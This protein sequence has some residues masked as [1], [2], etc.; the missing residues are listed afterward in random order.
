MKTKLIILSILVLCLSVAPAMADFIVPTEGAGATPFGVSSDGGSPPITVQEILDYITVDPL[1]KGK[2]LAQIAPLLDYTRAGYP[3]SVIALDDTILDSW[4]SYWNL[5]SSGQA[6]TTMIIEIAGNET[7]NVFGIYELG[8]PGNQAIVFDG[9]ATDG[10]TATVKIDIFGKVTVDN[11]LKAT[12]TNGTF[13]FFM[14]TTTANEGIFYSDTGLNTDGFDH[15]RAYQG[16]GTDVVQIGSTL[17]G[18]WLTNEFVLAW[19][20]LSGGGD[21]DWN[22]MALMVESV[23]PVPI[24]GAVLLGILGLSAA[25]IKLRR[26]A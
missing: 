8:N 1:Q 20:D 3:S 13:G 2:T 17:P 6:A 14:D 7:T 18:V 15:M 11:V 23:T 21:K 12:F 5:G 19:E 4:D 16:K 10:T 22:D 26:F 9:A 24:P 25:G